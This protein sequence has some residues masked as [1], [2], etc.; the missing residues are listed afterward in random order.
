MSKIQINVSRSLTLPYRFPSQRPPPPCFA[1][2]LTAPRPIVFSSTFT[3]HGLFILY[4]PPFLV[5]TGF[6][7]VLISTVLCSDGLRN[8]MSNISRRH[9][10][11]MKLLFIQGHSK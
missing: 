8:K 1:K 6:I 9:R 11:N 7:C 2:R 3:V 5:I 10:D 4:F